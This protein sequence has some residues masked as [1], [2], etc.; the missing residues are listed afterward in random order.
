MT[1]LNQ[2]ERKPKHKVGGTAATTTINKHGGVRPNAGRKPS[3][4]EATTVM[5]VPVSKKELVK[6][7]LQQPSTILPFPTIQQDLSVHYPCW[8][9]VLKWVMKS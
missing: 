3:Y 5:R 6:Q 9:R 8:V 7:F 4:D 1:D 2:P